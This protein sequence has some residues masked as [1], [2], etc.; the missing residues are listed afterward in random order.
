VDGVSSTSKW[1]SGRSTA[2]ASIWIFV[3]LMAGWLGGTAGALGCSE[4][5]TAGTTRASVC[6]GVGL[7]NFGGWGWLLFA[8]APALMLVLALLVLQQ[9]RRRPSLVGGLLLAML[10]AFDAITLM[11]VT[12]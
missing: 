12:S 6:T 5:L 3:L 9:A 11:L 7:S 8:S 1:I 10:V 4:N 2:T